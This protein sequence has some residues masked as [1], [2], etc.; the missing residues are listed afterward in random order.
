[1]RCHHEI[2]WINTHTIM[3]M[4]RTHTPERNM[5]PPRYPGAS[6]LRRCA[7]QE[8]PRW[9]AAQLLPKAL[10]LQKSYEVGDLLSVQLDRQDVA[11]QDRPEHFD[12][13]LHTIQR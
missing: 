6:S 8:L 10:H 13:L 7:W 5:F 2:P 12:G 11:W 3:I 9:A 4:T 1:M